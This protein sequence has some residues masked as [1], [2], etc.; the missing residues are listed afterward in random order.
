MSCGAGGRCS[1]DLVL[2]WRRLAAVPP[3]QPLAWGYATG[4]APKRRK[5]KT[6]KKET[7]P[8]IFVLGWIKCG[9]WGRD[10]EGKEAE[11]DVVNWGPLSEAWL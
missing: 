10:T 2:L 5:N 6:F 8:R 4:V 7:E 11:A 1:S 3:I 9:P